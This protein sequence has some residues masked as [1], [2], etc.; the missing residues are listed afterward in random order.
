MLSDNLGPCPIIAFGK[1]ERWRNE[2]SDGYLA[3]ETRQL[4]QGIII[5][6][7]DEIFEHPLMVRYYER[8][9]EDALDQYTFASKA[10]CKGIAVA[11]WSAS[12][13][14]KSNDL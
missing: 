7:L 3:E 1:T 4:A 2:F 14:S 10:Y 11:K 13:R 9:Y 8:N 6:S 12:L 5:A